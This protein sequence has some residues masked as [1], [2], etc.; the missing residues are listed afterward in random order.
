MYYTK[1][2]ITKDVISTLPKQ[3]RIIGEIELRNHG[4]H[5]K[6]RTRL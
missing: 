1:L 4:K 2:N 5:I 3:L 6:I